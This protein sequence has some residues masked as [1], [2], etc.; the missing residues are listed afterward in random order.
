[1][2]QHATKARERK[3]ESRCDKILAL[4][5]CSSSHGLLVPRDGIAN[6][7]RQGGLNPKCIYSE[8]LCSEV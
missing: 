2:E 7:H 1:V 6:A 3:L 5:G 8:A 4:R